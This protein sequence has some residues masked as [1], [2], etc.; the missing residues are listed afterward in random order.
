M[1]KTVQFEFDLLYIYIYSFSSCRCTHIQ[2]IERK[3][4]IKEA[5]IFREKTSQEL[6]FNSQNSFSYAS[7][8]HLSIF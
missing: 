5:N 2:R 4:F 3:I 7:K 1:S 8:Y 6:V